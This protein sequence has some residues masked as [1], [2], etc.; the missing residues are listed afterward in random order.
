MHGLGPI[1]IACLN[2]LGYFG[3]TQPKWADIDTSAASKARSCLQ[4]SG[5]QSIEKQKPRSSLD[6]G[7]VQI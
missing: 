5:S 7:S 4:F 2:E 6:Y 1:K 3:R